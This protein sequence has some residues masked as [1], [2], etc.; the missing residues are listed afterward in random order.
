MQHYLPREEQQASETLCS[1]RSQQKTIKNLFRQ[2]YLGGYTEDNAREA[3][4][5]AIDPIARCESGCHSPSLDT[6]MQE[7]AGASP[8]LW[9]DASQSDIDF[10]TLRDFNLMYL[11]EPEIHCTLWNPHAS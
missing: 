11:S 6:G 8:M 4:L 5:I 1:G 2:K 7:E 9:P 10:V 3:M